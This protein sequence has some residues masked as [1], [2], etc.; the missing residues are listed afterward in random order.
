MLDPAPPPSQK[1]IPV[2][3][4]F[5]L[6]SVQTGPVTLAA[7]EV[8]PNSHVD[9]NSSVLGQPV[10]ELK[11]E[12]GLDEPL[13]VPLDSV[14]DVN[15]YDF[16]KEDDISVKEEPMTPPRI[17]R[18]DLTGDDED[19]LPEVR[20]ECID[21]TSDIEDEFP[22]I[23]V[24]IARSRSIKRE[25]V[26]DDSWL[27]DSGDMSIMLDPGDIYSDFDSDDEPDQEDNLAAQDSG[28]QAPIEKEIKTRKLL[29]KRAKTAKE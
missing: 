26:N 24:I 4:A 3:L 9:P 7:V 5:E 28:Q 11:P 2:F 6:S 15:M 23:A 17:L 29:G 22:T 14:E 12:P 1:N 18:I 13:F 20:R 19:D 16:S 21:L 10:P 25:V 8:T 27:A